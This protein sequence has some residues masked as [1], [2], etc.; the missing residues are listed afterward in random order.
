MVDF[1]ADFSF[2]QSL[3]FFSLCPIFNISSFSSPSSVCVC[4]SL[5]YLFGSQCFLLGVALCLSLLTHTFSFSFSLLQIFGLSSC[6]C[7]SLSSLYLAHTSS[8]PLHVQTPPASF[9]HFSYSYTSLYTSSHHSVSQ[10]F[11]TPLCLSAPAWLSISHMH[12]TISGLLH[13]F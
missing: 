1:S 4:V 12:L 7:C 13:A 10:P 2:S 5:S 6:V 11:F 3:F 9:C 8:L